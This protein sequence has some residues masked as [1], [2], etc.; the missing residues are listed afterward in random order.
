MSP[1]RARKGRG[2]YAPSYRRW[3]NRFM[4]LVARPYLRFGE[5]VA[6]VR[7]EGMEYLSQ[8]MQRFQR[9]EERL[10]ILFRHVAKADAP[11]VASLLVRELP[12]WS[13]RRGIRCKQPPHA[14]FLYGKDVLN[15]AGAAARF[16]FP[17]IGGI[18][19]VNTRVD[20][21]SQ[22]TMRA[23]LTGGE[24]PL[25]FA[26][27][28]QVTYHMFRVSEL[29]PGTATLASWALKDLRKRGD[30]RPVTLLPVALGYLPPGDPEI[31]TRQLLNRFNKELGRP[32]D[33][34]GDL[35]DEL[36]HAAE[37]LAD[38][39]EKSYRDE[40]PGIA[41]FDES[42]SLQGR[43][44]R[45][46]D[47][48][49]RC[50]EAALGWNASAKGNAPPLE[51]IFRLRYRIMESLYRE[52]LDPG[53]LPPLQRARADYRAQVAKN[54]K[55]HEETADVLEYV[56]LDY[57]ESPGLLRRLEFVLNL[58]DVLNR[59]R[60]GNI[61][62]RYTVKNQRAL[63]HI[64]E[65]IVLTGPPNRKEIPGI[66]QRVVAGF[67]TLTESMEREIAED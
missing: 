57:L 45:L 8:A 11:V 16:L 30:G 40:Y 31:L 43:F 12:R 33:E 27:E 13:R 1:L 5:G 50:G 49:L 15:W 32:G 4:R 44:D 35:D 67:T 22:S 54:L 21:E 66:N 55:R 6:D 59:M 2:F 18:P 61:D 64:G 23:M 63:V 48:I 62:S 65:P 28:G 25:C 24:F 19:V 7:T 34:S 60:G 47:T 36:I 53:L 42:L 3:T 38:F 51:R 58:L 56:R 17:R 26:P 37:G 20:R 14:H 39:M 41:C 46:V 10:L 29:A 52:D 9:G